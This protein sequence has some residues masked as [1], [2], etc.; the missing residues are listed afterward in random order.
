MSFTIIDT[1]WGGILDQ[2]VNLAEPELRIICPFIK[3]ATARR[4]LAQKPKRIQVITRFNLADFFNG[5]NDTAALRHLLQAGAEIRGLRGLHAKMYLFGSRRVIVTSANLTAA[6][7]DR[8]HEFGFS[9]DEPAITAQCRTYFDRLWAL[10]GQNLTAARIDG[11]DIELTAAKA[12]RAN[13][14]AGARLRDDGA[15]A[16]A[17]IPELALDGVPTVEQAFVKFFAESHTRWLRSATVLSAVET[18]G[19]HWAATYP[20]SKR[21]RSVRD[22][23]TLFI[24][25]LVQEP[26]D[27][28]VFG[29]A[30]GMK[31]DPQRD[32][33]S[34][35]EIA[36]RS[37]KAKW[38]NYVRLHHPEFLAG[39]LANGVSLNEL[40]TALG[41]NA[42]ASTQRNLHAGKGKNVNPRRAFG[43]QPAVE[44]S[45]QGY[46]WLYAKL[47]EAFQRHGRL[48]VADL[49]KID[50][51]PVTA[52]PAPTGLS[53]TALR[54]LRT[55]CRF[56]RESWFDIR[57]SSTFPTYTTTLNEM[58][59]DIAGGGR[60]GGRFN[61]AG[62]K[63]LNEWLLANGH[64]ALTGI[65]VDGS[66]HRPGGQYF[67]SNG[68]KEEDLAWWRE[69]MRKAAAKTD[70]P[71]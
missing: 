42:F 59:V 69:E 33:A 61:Q 31:H 17:V 28:L 6:G 18:S 16:S 60:L 56:M 45:P 8:N 62:G 41:S 26:D 50:P 55:L 65:V 29:R 35:E 38:P 21:P 11:W 52:A 49:A 24:S 14:S 39:T 47:D 20:R 5:V 30:I 12:S 36:K 7:L 19:C 22:G 68:H 23:A 66:T 3:L 10:A 70:W 44:L 53:P 57:D 63:E 43:Q 64:P 4:I 71:I 1:G 32:V 9:A 48:P 51:L 2:A 27:I 67:V 13:V 37:W 46:Q 25:Y 34:A 15:D 40:M 58:G 54:L